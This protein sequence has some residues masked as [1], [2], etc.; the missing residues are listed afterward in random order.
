VRERERERERKDRQTSQ[1]V[2]SDRPVRQK[3]KK[4][5]NITQKEERREF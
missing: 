5:Y 1:T 4:I 2:Q 3:G